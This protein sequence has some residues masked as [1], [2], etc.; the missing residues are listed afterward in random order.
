MAGSQHPDAE[1]LI[2]SSI[3]IA[4]SYAHNILTLEH[5]AM[6]LCV[7]EP[8]VELLYTHQVDVEGLRE[9]LDEYLDDQTS[10]LQMT[11]MG[12]TVQKSSQYERLFVK[13][14]NQL[15]LTSRSTITYIDIYIGMTTEPDTFATYFFSKYGVD[16]KEMVNLFNQQTR[17]QKTGESDLA[18]ANQILEEF[19]VNL[20]GLA[21]NGKID[22]VIARESELFE[23]AQVLAKRN[24]SNV[25]LVGDPGVGKTAI[26]EGLARNI[27]NGEAPEFLKGWN[28]YNLDIGSLLAGSKYRGEFEEKLKAVIK[29]L[30]TKGNCVLFIDEAH[31]MRGAGSGGGSDVDF[32]NMIK[33]ALTRGKIRV[34]ASTTWEEYNTSF[35]KDRALMRRFYRV[36]VDEPSI[37]ASVQI[38]HGLRDN[39]QAFHTG[40]ITDSAIKTAVELSAR[41]QSDR[42]LPDKAIDLI[43]GA[44]A[45]RRVNNETDFTIDRVDIVNEISKATGIPSDQLGDTEKKT[46]I[47]AIEGN[48]KSAVFG[49]DSAVDTVLERV[50]LSKAGIHSPDRPLGV[51]VFLG[52]SGVGKTELAKQVSSNLGMNL[53]RFDM[54]EYQESN[55]VSRLIGTSPGYV[56]FD[57]GNVSGGLLVQQINQNP[58]SVILFDEIEKAHPA[59]S[60]VM[61]N[62]FDYGKITGGNGRQAD[63]RNCVIIMTSN[64]GAEKAEKAPAGFLNNRDG[65][66]LVEYDQYFR[67][68]FRNRVDA[69]I[70]FS[71]LDKMNLRQIVAKQL[72]ELNNQLA[73]QSI[74]LRLSEETVDKIIKEGYNKKMGARP[75]HRAIDRLIRIPLSRMILMSELTAGST[76]MAYL[77]DTEIKFRDDIVE[78]NGV[79][80]YV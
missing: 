69:V 75:L 35:E 21:E 59:L 11:S 71:Q 24:K 48:I 40:I 1:R 42:K 72:T 58:H 7:Y 56:G 26:A 36:T 22:P 54:G 3:E 39:L 65:E 66:E 28:V 20:N 10:N 79:T 16:R 67:P 19:C 13:I 18:R 73:E 63:A 52:P 78:K 27:V 61:L 8:F 55:S 30:E 31:Q 38:L 15:K 76:V 33:P 25:L 57:D 32:A 50:F 47:V 70:Q 68:E 4:Q 23:I 14:N 29:S 60:D 53:L 17:E 5:L 51:F 64:L 2:I 44:C 37:D 74:N 41:Y 62:L 12:E 43:D 9:D 46:D 77:E 34:I 49:Q 6:A 80:S 45:R